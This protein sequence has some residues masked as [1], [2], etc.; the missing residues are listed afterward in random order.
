VLRSAIEA[1]LDDYMRF[2]NIR[3]MHQLSAVGTAE[4]ASV[5]DRGL[6]L[7][8]ESSSTSPGAR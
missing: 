6:Y 4:E 5:D 2:A 1:A 8:A 3:E 7:C